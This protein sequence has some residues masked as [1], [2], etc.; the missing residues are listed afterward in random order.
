MS[1]K[2]YIETDLSFFFNCEEFA[3][4]CTLQ[5]KEEAEVDIPFIF[6]G[7]IDARN[8]EAEFCSILV[9]YAKTIK[10]QSHVFIGRE[11]WIVEAVEIYDKHVKRLTLRR[12]PTHWR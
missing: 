8:N 2:Q 7:S 6:D 3:E 1:L 10:R 4:I 11:D 12:S 5:Q 9:N